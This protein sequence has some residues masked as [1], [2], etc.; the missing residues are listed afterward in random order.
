M[1]SRLAALGLGLALLLARQ[2]LAQEEAELVS[3]DRFRVCADPAD[4]P[5]SNDKGEGFENKIAVL[6][7]TDMHKPVRYTFFP[8]S[9]GFIRATLMKD[10]C[11]V[12]MGTAVGNTDVTT[13]APYYYTGYVI[14]TRAAD[15]I[16]ATRLNDPALAGKRF[17]LIDETPPT[18][19][20]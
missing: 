1:I 20:L 13:T 17:G 7:G 8:D 4:L 18:N 5:F 11:D 3:P 16:T 19:L 12:V 2:A 14:V 9:Q 15:H 6:I 10:R